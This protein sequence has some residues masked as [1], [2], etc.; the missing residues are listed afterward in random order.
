MAS[1][2]KDTVNSDTSASVSS[3][4]PGPID[5]LKEAWVSFASKWKLLISVQIIVYLISV[6]LVGFIVAAGAVS[7]MGTN[8]F[9]PLLISILV[10][11][12]P[13]LVFTQIWGQGSMLSVVVSDE[14]KSI[15]QAVSSGLKMII[16]L[17]W[18][19][20]I[21]NFI[22]FGG[23]MLFVFPGIILN[24]WF[25]FAVL[26]F[27]VEGEK[28]MAA[29]LKSRE[30]VRGNWWG[31]FGRIAF[32]TLV[33]FVV[34]LPSMFL[35]EEFEA[36]TTI[37]GLTISVVMAPLTLCYL[38]VLYKKLID[39]RGPFE[40]TLTSGRKL[41]YLSFGIIGIVAVVVLI[42]VTLSAVYPLYNINSIKSSSKQM[43]LN[44]GIEN[45]EDSEV[46]N[47]VQ[48]LNDAKDAQTL[49]SLVQLQS[50]L[51]LYK[52]EKGTY[53][54]TLDLLV[55]THIE[56]LPVNETTNEVFS[57][58]S[59]GNNYSLC[60]FYG[61]ETHCVTGVGRGIDYNFDEMVPP[62]GY[63]E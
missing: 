46:F 61:G 6:S 4:L 45:T 3:T 57:Y 47:P 43:E 52:I 36:L 42:A 32:L 18:I 49:A 50:V 10:I 21:I 16:P 1:V 41:K 26:V 24:T 13:I 17:F 14:V 53:P 8:S 56:V 27:A 9:N 54:T 37:Y 59:D 23:F 19:G 60:T 5:I 2:S 62:P 11:L 30:Y 28:G 7:I 12:V 39:V 48:N 58:T 34:S 44:P 33:Y 63:Q 31:V 38:L 25:A 20:L 51:E 40:L 35:G 55:P 15:K 22:V 29:L